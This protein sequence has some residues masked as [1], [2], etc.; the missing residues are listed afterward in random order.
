MRAPYPCIG[1][2][3]SA[4]TGSAG[5]RRS[6]RSRSDGGRAPD[7]ELAELE[8]AWREAEEIAAIADDLLLPDAASERLAALRATV[9]PA[10]P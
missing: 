6:R 8:R 4:T 3:S 1:P 9:S 5:T 10:R 7:G 2:A